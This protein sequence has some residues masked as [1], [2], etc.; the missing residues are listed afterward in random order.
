VGAFKTASDAQFSTFGWQAILYPKGRYGLFNIPQG[1]SV[2]YQFVVNLTTGAWARFTGQ[3]AHCW[4]VFDG[5]LY[6]GGSE[7]VYKADNGD[8]D[9]TT[10]IP[11]VGKMAFNYFDAR[12]IQ[13]QFTMI[14]PV[15]ESNAALVVS[16]GFDVDFAQGDQYYTPA[17]SP[18]LGATWDEAVWDEEFWPVEAGN[19][20]QEWR[21]VRGI[22][23]C[24]ALRIKTSTTA[25]NVKW[26]SADFIW[27]PGVG[28]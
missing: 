10:A 25:Q 19:V 18:V 3:N 2:F 17:S 26:H 13:K 27:I 12:G 23:Y 1:S 11:G 20:V 21:S 6:F 5:E 14:R 15:M 4:V 9:D 24:G 16:I 28:L 22:G 8:K 7:K